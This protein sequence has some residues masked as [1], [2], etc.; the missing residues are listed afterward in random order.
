MAGP[1]ELR[2][3]PGT[4]GRP[5]R[6]TDVRLLDLEG[7]DVPPGAEG[8]IFARSGM[9]FEGYS[10]GSDK[11]RIDGFVA[12]GDVGHFDG[13]LLRVDGRDDEM[14]VSGGENVFPREVED[15]IAA[16]EGVVEAAVVGVEDDRFGQALVA[17]VVAEPDAGLDS[18]RIRQ[19]VRER[20]ASFKV[21]REVEFLDR[22]PRNETGKVVKRHIGG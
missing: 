18:D 4:A 7:A 20:L 6:G 22:L 3:D 19:H 16:I 8:R 13:E 17:Y 2:L 14:V 5:L 1:V 21:P 11:E 12:T 15:E 9:L 10:D